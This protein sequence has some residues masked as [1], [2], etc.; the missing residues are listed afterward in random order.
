MKTRIFS[1]RLAVSFMLGLL[2]TVAGSALLGGLTGLPVG[3]TVFTGAAVYSVANVLD[4]KYPTFRNFAGFYV[5]PLVTIFARDIQ[6]NLFPDNSFYRR[7]I[8]DD[9][10]VVGSKVNLPQAGAK[11]TVEVNRTSLPA[12]IAKRT[13]ASEEYDLAEFTSDPTLIQDTEELQVNYQKRRSV[14]FNHHETINENVADYAATLFYPTVSTFII[15]STGSN[16]AAS[17]PGATGNR[18]AIAKADII[19]ARKLL[20]RY[21]VPLNGRSMLINA[22]M[23][24]DL[25]AIEEFVSAEKIGE[26]ALKAGIIGRILGF[27]VF[28][29]S[30]VA[31]YATGNTKKAFG[32]ITATTDRAAALFWHDRAVR[33]AAGSPKV[34]EALNVPEY[35]GSI[36]SAMV[37]AGG[38][39]ARTDQKGVVALLEADPA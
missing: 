6:E 19:N 11:P 1:F 22:D 30:K 24:A 33:F 5:S 14:L 18:K 13:D 10:F 36:F 39:M 4:I 21:D 25:L 37:N 23:E 32:A 8:N 16:R 20:N 34:Y 12:T 27:D 9:A 2:M 7:S 31:T 26:P 28:V 38:R 35:Y 29:R 15:S 17:A 3:P